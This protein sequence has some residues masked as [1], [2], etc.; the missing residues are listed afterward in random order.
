MEADEKEKI[1]ASIKELEEASKSGDKAAIEAK[2]E[3]LGKVSQKLGEKVYAA[4]AE[5]NQAAGGESAADKPKDDNVVDA[6]FKEVD[7]K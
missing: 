6:D 5:K 1:E 2:T 3:E 7:K 4:M